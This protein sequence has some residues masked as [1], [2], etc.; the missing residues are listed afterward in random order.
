MGSE[1]GIRVC[2]VDLRDFGIRHLVR[3][4]DNNRED[5]GCE[6]PGSPALR[7]S[8]R[9]HGLSHIGAFG[10][11]L[12]RFLVVVECQ[13]G[14]SLFQRFWEGVSG[15]GMWVESGALGRCGSHVAAHWAVRPL[16]SSHNPR[17]SVSVMGGSGSP[18]RP[19]PL[20]IRTQ[21]KDYWVTCRGWPPEDIAPRNSGTR[22]EALHVIV[23]PGRSQSRLLSSWL[24]VRTST[25]RG[26]TEWTT[27]AAQFSLIQTQAAAVFFVQ[28]HP[29]DINNVRVCHRPAG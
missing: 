14:L 23:V 16:K 28:S 20:A 21:F 17:Q 2:N 11:Q 24:P 6:V 1:R 25:G 27:R 26:A 8:R 18:S 22:I 12:L 9:R 15:G 4:T 29:P 19:S 13:V 10:L 3:C 7:L 5:F